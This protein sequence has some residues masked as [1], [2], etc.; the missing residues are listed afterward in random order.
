MKPQQGNNRKFQSQGSN[1][2]LGNKQTNQR[3]AKNA[4]VQGHSE[5]K[6]TKVTFMAQQLEYLVKYMVGSNLQRGSDTEEELEMGFS[7]M[8]SYNLSLTSSH[9]WIIDSGASDHMIGCLE[10]LSNVRYVD[11][12]L[13]ITLP[14]W[15]VS[16][17]TCR[18]YETYEWSNFT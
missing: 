9:A 12:N 1:R 10:K 4:A 2:L 7:G 11:S 17:I 16:Q 8:I 5:D 6:T 18:R 3:M 14:I 13:T 15:A